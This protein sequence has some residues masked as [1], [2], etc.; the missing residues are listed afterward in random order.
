MGTTEIVQRPSLG[1]GVALLI[2]CGVLGPHT[3]SLLLQSEWTN[4]VIDSEEMKEVK[5]PSPLLPPCQRELLSFTLDSRGNLHRFHRATPYPARASAEITPAMTPASVA[6]HGAGRLDRAHRP[7]CRH[8]EH[9]AHVVGTPS[10]PA[11]GACAGK[12]C[13]RLVLLLVCRRLER[14]PRRPLLSEGSQAR[15]FSLFAWS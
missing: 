2:L 5:A 9:R 14:L 15:A 6:W 7:R 3:G 1:V 10:Y 8:A 4:I 12:N 11:G 13:R